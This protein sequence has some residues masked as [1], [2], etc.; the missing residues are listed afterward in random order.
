LAIVRVPSQVLHIVYYKWEQGV[1][2]GGFFPMG[3]NGTITT[4]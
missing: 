4:G 2:L 3:L 1:S